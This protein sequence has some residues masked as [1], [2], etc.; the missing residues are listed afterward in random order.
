MKRVAVLLCCAFGLAA[1]GGGQ[2]GTPKRPSQLPR[3][4]AHSWARQANAVAATLAR[5]DGCTAQRLAATL[6]SQVIAAVNARQVPRRFLEPLTSGVNELTSR[7]VCTPPRPA[8][9]GDGE[10][11][12]HGHGDEGD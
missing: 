10:H 11:K 1:C 8:A 7:I 12:G 9:P 4:L 5:G 6:Q 2:R 3:A